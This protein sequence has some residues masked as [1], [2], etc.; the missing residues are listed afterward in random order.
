MN[1]TTKNSH[2]KQN[3]N[4]SGKKAKRK[5]LRRLEAIAR[6]V[7]RI[8]GLES[9]L[10]KV[11]RKED[12]LRKITRAGVVLQCIRGGVPHEQLWAG[13]K[14]APLPAAAPADKPA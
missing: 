5:E 11:K 4:K 8:K 6:Q 12:H 14:T 1:E 10:N 3:N 9:R 2:A 7:E 13:P